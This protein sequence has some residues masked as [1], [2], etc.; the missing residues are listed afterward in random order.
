VSFDAL[1]KTY[2][3]AGAI[4]RRVNSGVGMVLAKKLGGIKV[5]IGR[6]PV[7]VLRA[8]QLLALSIVVRFQEALSALTCFSLAI[9]DDEAEESCSSVLGHVVEFI[10]I[11]EVFCSNLKVAKGGWLSIRGANGIDKSL[12]AAGIDLSLQLALTG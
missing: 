8:S 5:V 6:R 1:A 11:M 4:V 10:C 7:A 9:H 2:K 3:A 12:T